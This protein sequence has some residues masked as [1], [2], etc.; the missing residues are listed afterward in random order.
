MAT[1]GE[2]LQA[3]AEQNRK[4]PNVDHNGHPIKTADVPTGP[5]TPRAPMPNPAQGSGDVPVPLEYDLYQAEKQGDLITAVRIQE[6]IRRRD[7]GQ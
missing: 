6:Q 1:P 2:V 4:L 3:I 7:T 5:A